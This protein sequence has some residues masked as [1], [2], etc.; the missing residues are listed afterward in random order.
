MRVLYLRIEFD[1][2]VKSKL[3]LTLEDMRK[4]LFESQRDDGMY[5]DN[6]WM[7]DFSPSSVVNMA[8]RRTDTI[9]FAAANEGNLYNNLFFKVGL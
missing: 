1:Q 4:K 7:V 5:N 9:N 6:R 2:S 8:L 3:R